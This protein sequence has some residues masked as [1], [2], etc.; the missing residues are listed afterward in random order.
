VKLFVKGKIGNLVLKNRIVMAPMGVP[1]DVDGGYT[2]GNIDYLVE[3]AKGGAGMIIA[4]ATVVSERFEPR[5][6]NLLNNL[7]QNDRLGNLADKVHMYGAKLGLQLSPG[8]GR[9]SFIDPFTPPYS[10]SEIPS[11]AFPGLICKP[12]PV[13]GIKHLVKA[14]G[15][16]AQLAQKAGVD[17]VE[18]HAYGGYLIDQ[19]MSSCWNKRT[20]E[21]GGSLENRMQFL[22]EII[23]EIR[24][25]CGRDYPLAVKMTVDGMAPGER[26]LEEGMAIVKKLADSPIDL[27]H[28]GRGSY[29][30]RYRMV[31]SVY[32]PKGFD[33]DA[34]AEVKKV[35]KNIPVMGHGKLNHVDIAEKALQDG[36]MD[37]VAIGHGFLA[38]PHWPNKVKNNKLDDIIPCIGCAEC[39]YGA[40]KGRI[41]TC[42]VNPRTGHEK[43]YALTKAAKD[44]KILVIG[45]GPGG[46][47][48]AITA[49]KRGFKVAL[50][51]KK[52]TM[53][54]ELS[55]AGAPRFKT[56]VAD[57]VN[58]LI[59]EVYKA[60][61]DRRLGKIVTLEDVK[62]YNP[63]FVVVATGSNPVMI[64]VPG[65]DKSHVTLA[66]KVLLNE[67]QVGQKVVVI[68]GG[69]VGCETALELSLQGKGVTI[70]EMLDDILK[71]ADHFVAND[72]N[73]RYL[74]AESNVHIMTGTKLTEILDNGI[75][76][77]KDGKLGTIPCDSVVFAAGF[78][79][80]H[81][82]YDQIEEAGFEVVNIGDN[83]KP[84]KVIDAVHQAY[85]AMR[86]L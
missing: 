6:Y 5:P 66:E 43:E 15:Y 68:G 73:L 55:A 30:C 9:I 17:M 71:V 11:Y 44:R 25:T 84:G 62:Q 36:G 14:M 49:A 53:G 13:E 23:E 54:G 18:I 76:A 57:Q 24:K 86:I 26:P 4:G 78:R 80:D 39:H 21:Y 85:H 70:V 28:I 65:Y 8:I 22:M 20:D 29:S 82:L 81:S 7:H 19:F 2:K 72:Q 46:M 34:V 3:R 32:Q 51:E 37:Y 38:D 33:V 52:T 48:A 47:T 42:A 77:E 50:W 61:I 45:A 74:L 63:D 35:I 40:M 69:L 56:D 60:D 79:S 31:S 41:L 16:S 59:R 27:L 67:I 10:S 12:L 1:A 64:R 75:K 58:Y 83:V